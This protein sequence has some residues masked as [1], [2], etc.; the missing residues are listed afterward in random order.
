[1]KA[2]CEFREKKNDCHHLMLL[3]RAA[4]NFINLNR[5]RMNWRTFN[6]FWA[7]YSRRIVISCCYSFIKP[8]YQP[9]IR[10]RTAANRC[11]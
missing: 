3:L 4:P 7:S 5:Y 6:L 10:E 8:D 9:P 11:K 1:M 2:I